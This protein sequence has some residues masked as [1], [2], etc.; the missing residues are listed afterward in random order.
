MENVKEKLAAAIREQ[1]T[2]APDTPAKSE[3][4]EE[5]SDNLYA[6]YS[7]RTAAGMDGEAAYQ[8]A[9][10]D[11]GDTAELVDYL[12]SLEPGQ[13]LPGPEPDPE[14]DSGDFEK[15]LKNIGDI[16]R[17]ALKAAQGAVNAVDVDGVVRDA[18]D[19][20]REVTRQ[21][22]DAVRDVTDHMKKGG[23]YTY[24]SPNGNIHITV[25]DGKPPKPPKP[26]VV[27][28]PHGPGAPPP[29]PPPPKSPGPD[30]PT[31][32]ELVLT[33]AGSD[34]VLITSIDVEVGGDVTVRTDDTPEGDVVIG[35]SLDDL[36]VRAEG[37]ALTIRQRDTASKGFFLRRGMSLADVELTLPLRPWSSL[38]FSTSN[39]AL[40]AALSEPVDALE[41][42]T[43]CGDVD[44]KLDRCGRLA[45][46]SVNGDVDLTAGQADSVDLRTVSG[47][48]EASVRR[49]GLLN[50]STVNGDVEWRGDADEAHC[51]SVSGDMELG[52]GYG[53][54]DLSST[55]GDLRIRANSEGAVNCA[56]I[57]GDVELELEALPAALNVTTR[58]GDV[59]VNLPGG[60]PFSVDFQTSSGELSSGF[61][62]GHLEGRHISFDVN[63]GGPVYRI[64]TASGDCALNKL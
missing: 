36:D 12:N 23:S 2:G 46:N 59:E 27:P 34:G 21:A 52:G 35:G 8:S 6:R 29:P 24:T 18:V 60:G 33:P 47:D 30:A 25:N 15:M 50:I 16:V 64:R 10:D 37:G 57:S 22:K 58:S 7:D 54:L 41:L 1:L 3:L 14:P 63:G 20:A 31:P 56:A 42:R 40:S 62:P 11:L 55:S 4:V 48:V 17:D 44:A 53:S 43:A 5:L 61:A 49:C 38:R 26:P 19:S 45:V 9:L 39:G 32:H 13:P 51:R 28:G